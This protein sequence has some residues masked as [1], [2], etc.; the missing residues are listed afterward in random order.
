MGSPRTFPPLRNL[1]KRF[2]PHVLFLSETKSNW[3]KMDVIRRKIQFKGIHVVNNVGYSG[4]LT[5]PW[6]EDVNVKLVGSS[7]FFID[8]VINPNSQNS[9]RFTGCFGDP[10]PSQRVHS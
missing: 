10:D 1:I 8:V 4:V 2:H 3:A 5:L 9:W 6:T 7:K